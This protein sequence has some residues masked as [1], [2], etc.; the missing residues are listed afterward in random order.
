MDAVNSEGARQKAI[1]GLHPAK[2]I[3]NMRTCYFSEVSDN[4]VE[5]Q[6]ASRGDNP[7]TLHCDRGDCRDV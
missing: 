3:N 6:N 5:F 2:E 7:L 4:L 1:H